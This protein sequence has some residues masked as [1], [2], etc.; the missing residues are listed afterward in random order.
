[1]SVGVS[2]IEKYRKIGVTPMLFQGLT[3]IIIQIR[4][5]KVDISSICAFKQGR[6]GL[7]RGGVMD[8]LPPP[9]VPQGG[10]E[11]VNRGERG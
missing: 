2:N 5:M 7:G 10:V 9:G 4:R 1:M 3:P 11:G 6:M 8:I